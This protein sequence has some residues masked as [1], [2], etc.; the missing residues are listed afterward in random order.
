[1][2]KGRG[3][4]PMLQ[5][6][7]NEAS[8][9]LQDYM[10]A[11]GINYQLTPAGLHRHNSTRH[12]NCK[13]K[14]IAGLCSTDP[15]FPLNPWDKT[16]QHCLITLNLL[17]ASKSTHNFQHMPRSME[18]FITIAPLSHRQASESSP[19]SSRRTGDRSP[20]MQKQDTTSAR[21]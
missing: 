9:I 2:R 1:M 14:F 13:K 7:D 11:E 15:R 4:T 6:L 21:L 12:L 19:T 8:K 17:S 20:H 16:L 10:A 18:H 3:L 5:R